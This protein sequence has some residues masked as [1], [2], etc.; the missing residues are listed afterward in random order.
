MKSTYK[1]PWTKEDNPNGWIEVTTFCQLKCT[2]CYRGLA[3][4][5]PKRVH[6][7]FNKI[8]DEI[9]ELIKT[10]NI[11]TL[12]IAGGEPLLYP[13]I[14]E[15][16]QYATNKNLKTKIFTNGIVLTPKTLREFKAVG[17]TEFV[18]HVD[19]FQNRF[20][21]RN[22]EELFKLRE[23]Y[24]DM[25]REIGTINLGFIMP[26]SGDNISEIPKIIDF[27]KKNSDVINLVVFSTYKNALPNTP[28]EKLV[29]GV[30]MEKLAAV[31]RANYHSEPC[32]YLGKIKTDR[33]SWLFT[34]PLFING[35]VVGYVDGN[36]YESLQK[37][38]YKRKGKY[39]ITISGN[40]VRLKS[41]LPYIFRKNLFKVV[42]NL[43]K[44]LLKERAMP[45]LRYQVILIIDG[46]DLEKSGWDLCDGCPDAMF[47]NG[48]LVP[49]CLLERIKTGEEIA[50]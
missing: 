28:A 34:M 42:L 20:D 24:C 18:I 38:Y 30:P 41:V 7:S 11:Q 46:P 6:E 33:V 12:S 10:R 35:Q 14:K 19:G 9:D 47:H 16:I 23:K 4:D 44:C 15:V 39:F 17:A 43:G 32:A 21:A 37:R 50:V 31:V 26:V 8:T 27:Y 29:H 48:K 5:N 22:D 13:R 40:K 3:E 45:R 49:S 2:A 25:F 1:L 36:M